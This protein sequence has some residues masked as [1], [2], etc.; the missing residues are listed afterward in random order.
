MLNKL[1]LS[2]VFSLFILF[3]TNLLTISSIAP[4]FLTKQIFSWIIGLLLFFIGRHFTP[5]QFSSA[6][7]PIFLFSCFL[8][9]LP[10]LLNNITRG[11]RRWVNVGPLSFQPSEIV[12]PGL[13]IY[14]ANANVLSSYFF[15]L[16]PVFIVI[17]QPDLGSAVSL[18]FLLSPVIFCHKLL[19]KISLIFSL[20]ILFL[21]PLIWT[22]VLHPYQQ[23]RIL[24]FINPASDPFDQGYNVIQSKIAIG[25]GGFF[26]KGYKKGSQGRLL[27]LPE[28]H[29]DFIFAAI[30]EELGFLGSFLIIF[31]YFLLTSSLLKKAFS[32]T[33]K[34]YFI[35]TLGITF[36]IW[37]QTF[38]NIGMNI[39]ILPV[40]GI[41][42]PFLS[43][44]G[45]SIMATLFSL[46]I[47]HSS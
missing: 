11:S 12:K 15:F 39:G 36:Q 40:T 45:S 28:K 1:N 5:R 14:L 8:L 10:I 26:G 29:T 2:I 25:S 13:M 9:I 41:P 44:G 24:N 43:V 22:K 27:F 21:S 6:K 18:L 17:L 38:V 34:A 19:F 31:A 16:I 3:F 35:F 32:S 20:L 42:L 30:S 37:F 23:E 4:D 7:W 33:N 47:I 46:G